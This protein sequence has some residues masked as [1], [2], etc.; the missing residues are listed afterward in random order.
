[1]LAK[2]PVAQQVG[3]RVT[4]IGNRDRSE[5]VVKHCERGDR[6]THAVL[7]ERR[8]CRVKD[9]DVCFGDEFRQ[10]LG[11]ANSTRTRDFS[12]TGARESAGPMPSATTKSRSLVCEESSFCG[13][14]FPV[15]VAEPNRAVSIKF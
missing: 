9:C 10:V 4:D 15:S 5:G 12:G 13:R 2:L 11:T 1:H 3:P 8:G 7:S 14:K 6:G